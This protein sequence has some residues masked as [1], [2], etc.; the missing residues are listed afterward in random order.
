MTVKTAR[1][2]ITK[3]KTSCAACFEDK[4]CTRFPKID[5]RAFHKISIKQ[6]IAINRTDPS[7]SSPTV[8]MKVKLDLGSALEL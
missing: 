5:L 1:S 6:I 2:L 3:T 8:K 7:P 4:F